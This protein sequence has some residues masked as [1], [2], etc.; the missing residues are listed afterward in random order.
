MTARTFTITMPMFRLHNSNDR[1]VHWADRARK[2]AEMRARARIAAQGLPPIVGRAKLTILFTFPDARN[3]DLDNYCCKGA[4][5]GAVDAKVISDDRAKVL[6]PVTR[7]LAEGHSPKGY[8]V[9]TFVF[10]EVDD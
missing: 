7:D 6:R 10:S 5:D 1:H 8:A 4:I 3:R 2:R 9:L